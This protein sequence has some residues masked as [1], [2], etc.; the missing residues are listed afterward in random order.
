MFHHIEKLLP[1]GLSWRTALTRAGRICGLIAL[2]VSTHVWSAPVLPM[3]VYETHGG[4]GQLSI[5]ANSQGGQAF[6]LLWVGANGHQ[7]Q[8]TGTIQGMRGQ[9]MNDSPE[10]A[11]LIDFASSAKRI[12]VSAATRDTCRQY[13]GLRAWFED[14]YVLPPSG[15]AA[16][17]RKARR[18]T[19]LSLFN[20]HQYPDALAK[21]A[22]LQS[23]CHAFFSWIEADQVSNALA[24]AHWH[25]G[26]GPR[27]LTVLRDTLGA[28]YPS[29]DALSAVLPPG[30][31]DLYL[32]IAQA[33]WHNLKR[34][35]SSLQNKPPY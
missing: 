12:S 10:N 9:A 28:K 15:C 19:A 11:C 4:N 26:D 21:L 30:D 35:T 22:D 33:T 7:C 5:S 17:A 23:T 16:P 2:G 32:P 6:E 18:Q 20:T 27:C 14:D 34:C 31:F 13:C 24:D 8:L 3:G 25:L 29:E 1:L